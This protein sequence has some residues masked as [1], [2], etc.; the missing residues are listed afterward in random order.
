MLRA[1]SERIDTACGESS[2]LLPLAQN[3]QLLLEAASSNEVVELL[4][5]MVAERK[6]VVAVLSKHLQGTIARV[7]FLSFVAEQRWPQFVRRRVAEL[8]SL[9]VAELTSA[10]DRGDVARLESLFV[11]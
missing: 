6:R 8:S 2:E 10:L 7:A 9:E 3:M 5:E 1:V 11:V 4:S